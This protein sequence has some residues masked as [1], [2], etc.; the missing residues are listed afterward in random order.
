MAQSMGSLMTSAKVAR[1]LIALSPAE[2]AGSR[3]IGGRDHRRDAPA[4][5]RTIPLRG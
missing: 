4:L 5:H 2:G 3:P 1:V